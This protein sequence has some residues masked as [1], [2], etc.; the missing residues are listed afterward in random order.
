M[1]RTILTRQPPPFAPRSSYPLTQTRFNFFQRILTLNPN[2]ALIHLACYF[3][4]ALA[5]AVALIIWL[6]GARAVCLPHQWE[7]PVQCAEPLHCCCAPP[8]AQKLKDGSKM[9][10]T[11]FFPVADWIW[12]FIYWASLMGSA[13]DKTRCSWS[14]ELPGNCCLHRWHQLWHWHQHQQCWTRSHGRPWASHC[15][16]MAALW[17]QRGWSGAVGGW[18]SHILLVVGLWQAVAPEVLTKQLSQD[19]RFW[20]FD[21]SCAQGVVLC[22]FSSEKLRRS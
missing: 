9:C 14:W 17:R 19:E 5:C 22:L 8:E 4:P 2:R 15:S 1:H 18:C 21:M 6:A 16:P 3:S 12:V 7:K 10:H 13:A 20:H 11:Q